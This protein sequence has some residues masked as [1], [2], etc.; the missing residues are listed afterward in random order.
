MIF[1]EDVALFSTGFSVATAGGN[2]DGD[3]ERGG[4]RCVCVCVVVICVCSF[5][6]MAVVLAVVVMGEGMGE[7]VVGEEE[8]GGACVCARVC[9][10]GW[11]HLNGVRICNGPCPPFHLTHHVC[12][13]PYNTQGDQRTAERLPVLRRRA[14]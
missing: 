2:G 4:G 13:H 11:W 8:Q 6:W 12:A 10:R 7:S 9:V 14:R 3:G 1:T 5:V